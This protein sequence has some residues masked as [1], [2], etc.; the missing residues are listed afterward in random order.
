MLSKLNPREFNSVYKIMEESFS[1]N[2]RRPYEEQYT[3]LERSNYHVYINKDSSSGDIK[4]FLAIWIFEEFTFIEHFAVGKQYRGE[5]LGSLLLSELSNKIE[6]QLCLEVEPPVN[7]DAIRRIEFY[8]RNGFYLNNYP[9]IQP[10]ISK[11]KKEL[12]LLIMTS[13]GS[14]TREVF[15]NYKNILYKNVYSVI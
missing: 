3:L 12:P 15:E 13:G 8:K 6:C 9:Y 10:P 5:G 1:E 11:G 14:I 2:E 4:A 7:V